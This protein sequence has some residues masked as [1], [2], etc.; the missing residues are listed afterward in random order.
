MRQR[1]ARKGAASGADGA[2]ARL[3][4]A[5]AAHRRGRLDLAEPI[6]RDILRKAPDHPDALHL[7][8]L[9]AHQRGDQAAAIRLI[10]RAL[11]LNPSNAAYANS[12]GLALLA[13]GR[14]ADADASFARAI[15]GDPALAEAHNN[16]G[17]ARMRAGDTAG[18]IAA[19]ERAIALR[20]GYAEAHANLA[21]SLRRAGN[22][23]PAGAAAERALT[24]RPA[25]TG[26]LC[27]LG[28]IRHEQ[29]EYEAALAAYD[30]ALTLDPEHATTRANRATLL[31]LLGRMEEGWREYEW[32]WRAQGFTTKARDFARPP[33]DGSDLAGRTILIHAEQGLGS[34]I[35]F[36][37]YVPMVA[38]R[39]GRVILE[40]QPPLARLFASLAGGGAEAIVRKGERL[41]D[42]A[43]HAPLMSLPQLLGTT[44]ATI[45]SAVPYLAAEAEVS[46]FWRERLARVPRPRVGLVW[47]GN[48][49]HAN[50]RNRSLPARTLAPLLT[51]PG[52]S[53]IDLQVGT[54]AGERAD[55]A[56]AGLISPGKIGDVADTAAII[57][58]LDLVVSVD[59]AVSHLA[60]ALAKPVWLMLPLVGEWRWLRE[61]TDTPW[62]PTMRLFRQRDPGDWPGVVEAMGE[63]LRARVW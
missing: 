49:N 5:V 23:E 27:T 58:E 22:L 9:V 47:A 36:V 24:I 4:E 13:T 44:L 28:L 54:A 32:R 35:Q 18:A 1:S 62:Y 10:E 3:A 61:R 17:N 26:A 33:W 56:E 6:Y 39:G 16:L 25:Y 30:R 2:R 48:P 12:F 55:L 14:I 15:A 60:G 57:A 46:T 41:P 29:G 8:G 43:V 40:C 52:I 21:A 59:P 20:P 7:L 51:C 63:A 11:R 53:F 42:F 37:R 19:Y 31:L 45:P 50:D 38:A 34:A